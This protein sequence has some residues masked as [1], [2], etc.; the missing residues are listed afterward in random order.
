MALNERQNEIL[1]ILKEKKKANVNDLAQLFYVSEA[2]IRRDLTEMHGMGLVERS[3]GGALLPENSEEI[4]IFFRME[5]N[6][7]E[8]E[9]AATKALPYIPPFKSVF[10]DSS[11][12]VLA[13]AERM[14][15]SHKT[16][17]TN[18]L[19]TAIQLSKKP[20]VTLVMLGGMVQYN[21]I[22]TT[23]SWTARLLDD[24]KFDLMISSCAAVVDGYAYE[25]SLDQK[26]IKLAAFERS[27]KRILLIDSTKFGAHGSY[28]LT[29]LDSYDF[30]VTD[31]QP[32][33]DLEEKNIKFIY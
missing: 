5:K 22:S 25:R 4:S 3:H 33:K 10:I 24:F 31:A 26:E 29:S 17:V 21:T 32:P 12:T 7:Q 11:S 16:V 27:Q 18:N 19:Q 9:R 14:D 13:L 28:R 15:F 20:N 30:V 1:R 6:A 8:K 23:G 2:T